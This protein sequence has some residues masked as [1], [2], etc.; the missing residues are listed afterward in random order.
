MKGPV[1]DETAACQKNV[2]LPI[3]LRLV[4]AL[5]LLVTEMLNC[6]QGLIAGRTDGPQDVMRSGLLGRR[7]HM[8]G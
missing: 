5:D 2:A 6:I 7:R 1:A 8:M 3:D 4:Q